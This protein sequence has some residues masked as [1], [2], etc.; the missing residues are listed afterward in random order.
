MRCALRQVDHPGDPPPRSGS[1]AGAGGKECVHMRRVLRTGDDV[2]AIEDD[3]LWSL[4]LGS[5]EFGSIGFVD[6]F[7][8]DLQKLADYDLGKSFEH[9]D[10]PDAGT[11]STNGR[12]GMP[13][14]DL[15][16]AKG[17]NIVSSRLMLML[18]SLNLHTVEFKP[19]PLVDRDDPEKGVLEYYIVFF[20]AVDVNLDIQNSTGL[21]SI[22]PFFSPRRDAEFAFFA[23]QFPQDEVW[24]A[25]IVR[26]VIF[27]KGNFVRDFMSLS[28]PDLSLRECLITTA[29]E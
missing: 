14:H 2:S 21:K 5:I 27:L 4:N 16:S 3:S 7:K 20:R 25:A 18:K 10:F 13:L 24:S 19:F 17:F 15:M 6:D 28:L 29:S 9:E 11:Y 23:G 22:G 8:I 1:G 12:K 26:R